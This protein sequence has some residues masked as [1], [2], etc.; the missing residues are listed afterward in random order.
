MD[1]IYNAIGTP[2][3]ELMY[4]CFLL[5]GGY[6]AAI[7]IFTVC[8]KIVLFPLS[9][10]A[11]KNSIKMVKMQPELDD[12]KAFNSGNGE[13]IVQETKK[14]YKREHYSTILGILPLLFQIPII[15]GLID[16]IYKPL[17]YLL[18]ADPAQIEALTARTA[19]LLGMPVSELG[20]GAQLR[21]MDAVTHD[22]SAFANVPSLS[23]DIISQIHSVDA[24]FLGISLS[25][26]P[27]WGSITILVPLASGLSA[28]LL[29][30]VQNRYNVLQAE[31]GFAGKWG[32]TIFLVAFSTY[33]AYA[34]PG[35]LGLYWTAGNLL[36]IPVLALCN[37]IFSPK[38][39]I[40][41]ENRT[42]KVKPTKEE[43]A[44]A[45]A[46]KHELA[47]RE[48]ADAKRFAAT[49]KKRFV[50]YSEAK[51]YYKY[52][53]KIIDSVIAHSEVQIHYVTSDP[54]DVIFETHHEN[55]VPYYIG[56][57]A[58]I[59]FMMRLDADMVLMTLP[60]LETYH[61]KRSI[62]RKD[63]EYIYTDHGIGSFH[64]LLRERAL[65]HFDTV[66]CYGPNH[67]AEVRETERVYG[68]PK[69]TLVKT[70][71]GLLDTL[72]ENVENMK[73][74]AHDRPQVLIA[75]SW[76]KDNI[77]DSCLDEL[78]ANLSGRGYRIIVRPHPEYSKRFPRKMENILERHKGRDPEELQFETDFSS[79]VSVY[80]SDLLITDW[81]SIAMDFSFAR[82]RPSLFINTTMK[83]MNPNYGNIP[84]VPIDLTLRDAIGVSVEPAE[85][86]TVADTVAELVSLSEKDEWE[87]RID[88]VLRETMYDLGRGGEEGGKY[89]AARVKEIEY[90]ERHPEAKPA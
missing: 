30:I 66:F 85:L 21:V 86:G 52:F 39:Y 14:L 40:D 71:F 28:L 56:P 55:I 35:G 16:V 10:I 11:Q 57:R 8:T 20:Y 69:K 22:P 48:K 2:L 73:L 68:L 90:V 81:S 17:K 46:R 43:R 80:S 72:I 61:I 79:N 89:I 45:K 38:K 63:I 67:V 33:F 29:C 47:T 44:A 24:S 65:D 19:E 13:L 78:I 49:P 74:D 84:C 4:W 27:S 51:G 15:L 7:I 62:V 53:E 26:I 12:I 50:I 83:I 82:K 36:S 41:Y 3:G 32:M 64:L 9:L 54:D 31:A 88:K 5:A 42:I 25:E 1:F 59:P 6:G 18:K 23:A 77:M 76:Q 34:L 75:P 37:L 87:K 58:L 70:G 60:D